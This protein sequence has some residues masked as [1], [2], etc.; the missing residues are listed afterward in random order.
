MQDLTVYESPNLHAPA[1]IAAFA[2]WGDAAGAATGAVKYLAEH[3]GATKL[4]DLDPEPYYD[5]TQ[6]RPQ[7]RLDERGERYV[8]WPENEFFYWKGSEQARDLLFFTGVEPSL[9]W[10]SYTTTVLDLAAQHG[11]SQMI[12]LG[13][14]LDSVPH[15]REPRISGA[16]TSP[17]LRQRLEALGAPVTRYQGP[18]GIA[19]VLLDACRRRGL[20]YVSLWGHC[21]HYLQAM[22]NPMVTLALLEM[23][24][25]LLPVTVDLG[26]LRRAASLFR[27]ELDKAIAQEQRLEQ[28]VVQLEQA[29]DQGNALSGTMPS[30]ED[31]MR[32]LDDFLRRGQQDR[33]G[34]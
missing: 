28:Y 27:E 5:F 11:V 18:T 33:P 15:T 29:Y 24:L 20:P 7:T 16:A 19:G 2:G 22:V 9:R 12:V 34:R 1:L 21:P 31:L 17:E 30:P 23:T 8:T 26:E 10:R 32:D 6:V 13:A 3:L 4:A 25:R 14:L